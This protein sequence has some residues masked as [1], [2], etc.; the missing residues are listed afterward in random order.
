M[1]EKPKNE[2]ERIRF[3]RK[4]HHLKQ[5][6]LVKKLTNPI[7]VSSLSY[8][9]RGEMKLTYDL[10]M[11]F[12]HIFGLDIRYFFGELSFNQAKKEYIARTKSIGKETKELSKKKNTIIGEVKDGV[13]LLLREAIEALIHSKGCQSINDIFPDG[14]DNKNIELI[15][16]NRVITNKPLKKLVKF[17]MFW[18]DENLN[19]LNDVTYGY[20]EGF[21][22]K[23]KSHR[24]KDGA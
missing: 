16:L 22:S 10:I 3:A 20:R 6:E 21:E 8:I 4:E 12:S 18:D 9:E 24:I 11:D 17:I 1:I 19:R 2:Y 7:S 15:M 23:K 13:V 14:I 5:T